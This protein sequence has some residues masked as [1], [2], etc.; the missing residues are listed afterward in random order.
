MSD[1]DTYTKTGNVRASLYKVMYVS[2]NH[3]SVLIAKPQTHILRKS[4]YPNSES[5]ST[6]RYYNQANLHLK[7]LC[8]DTRHLNFICHG[9]DASEFV[10]FDPN[11]SPMKMSELMGNVMADDTLPIH[12]SSPVISSRDNV[13]LK[14]I[15]KLIEDESDKHN[16]QK[17]N[18]ELELKQN[19]QTIIEYPNAE[20]KTRSGRKITVPDRL[21]Y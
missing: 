1:P 19:D 2:R 13:D 17:L 6:D 3:K 16:Q 14:S 15:I 21:T 10:S 11:W 5:P 9:D 7:Y 12:I 20:V 8:R 18:M 4:K